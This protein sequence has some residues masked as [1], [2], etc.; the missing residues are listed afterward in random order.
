MPRVEGRERLSLEPGEVWRLLNDPDVLGRSIPGCGG[1][2]AAAD[3]AYRA[4]IAVAVGAVKGVYAGTVEYRDVVAPERCTIAVAAR[5]E[6]GAIEG[7][8]RL[9]LVALEGETDVA[10]EGTFK[11]TGPVAGMGQRLAPGISRK[12]IVE[13]LR[14]LERV[15]GSIVEG[16]PASL[17]PSTAADTR[18]G[19]GEPPAAEV[20]AG[21]PAAPGP[22]PFRL[23]TVSPRV[24]FGLGVALGA[25]CAVIVAAA[26][27]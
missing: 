14:N 21:R 17:E 7:E 20:G 2:E 8:G 12:L 11:L 16:G 6:K 5:G 26:L 3:G 15:G 1:F 24:A 22:Q 10:Y 25:V 19:A 13:T 27:G 4:S 23:L 9:T 18:V